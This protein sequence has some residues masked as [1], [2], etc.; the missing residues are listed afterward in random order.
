MKI[1]MPFNGWP[2]TTAQV[3]PVH[4]E[5]QMNSF[6]LPKLSKSR[7]KQQEPHFCAVSDPSYWESKF[8]VSKGLVSFYFHLP[9][10]S[11]TV[12][13]PTVGTQHLVLENM[14]SCSS[15]N[16]VLWSA[17]VIQIYQ[18][19]SR[20]LSSMKCHFNKAG[21]N[22]S[23]KILTLNLIIKF[24]WLISFLRAETS[25]IFISLHLQQHNLAEWN[26]SPRALSPTQMN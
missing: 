7:F 6:C 10:W 13:D 11:H 16:M 19:W 2:T 4:A 24:G 20:D 17:K 18:K 3:G 12:P 14:L 5:D 21:L 9:L 1:F 22:N 26:V 23:W 25:I 15:D 8:I